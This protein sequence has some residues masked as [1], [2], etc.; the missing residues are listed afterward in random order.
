[1]T[2]WCAQYQPLWWETAAAL[3]GPEVHQYTISYG[4]IG[5]ILIVPTHV[6]VLEISPEP[7]KAAASGVLLQSHAMY[8]VPGIC[9][10]LLNIG[11]VLCMHLTG[12][13]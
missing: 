10:D 13:I 12:Q 1:M 9:F 8:L 6:L 7:G 5:G 4:E 3:G 11:S 2:G